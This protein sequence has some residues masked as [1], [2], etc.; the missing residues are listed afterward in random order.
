[1][2]ESFEYAQNGGRKYLLRNRGD[3]TFEDV[4]EKVG[5]KSTRW[6]LGVVAA[7]LCGTGYPDIVLANDY[8]V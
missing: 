4:T 6:T 1:M 3:G 7:D 5:I 8:G 2:P